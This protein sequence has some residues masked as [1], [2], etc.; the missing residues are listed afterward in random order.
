[1]VRLKLGRIYNSGKKLVC[2]NCESDQ[3]KCFLYDGSE[4]HV[5]SFVECMKCKKKYKTTKEL[6]C[7]TNQKND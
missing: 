5:N 2:L 6:V 7:R 3:F 4:K 1:M